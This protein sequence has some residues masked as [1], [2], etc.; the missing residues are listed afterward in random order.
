MALTVV[1][2]GGRTWHWLMAASRKDSSEQMETGKQ[3]EWLIEH[4]DNFAIGENI[5]VDGVGVGVGVID[6]AVL[7]AVFKSGFAPDPFLIW[8]RAKEPRTLSDYRSWWRSTITVW[9]AVHV[10]NKGWT[11]AESKSSGFPFLNEFLKGAVSDLKDKGVCVG[12]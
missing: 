8:W 4:S 10:G 3:A 5:A 6:G 2:A 7:V 1:A 9:V 11:A 12:I